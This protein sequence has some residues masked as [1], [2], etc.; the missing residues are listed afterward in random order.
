MRPSAR[1]LLGAAILLLA[2]CAEV[3]PPAASAAVEEHGLTAAQTATELFFSEYVE[4]TSNHKALEIYNGTGAAVDLGAGGYDVQMFFNGSPAA[5]LTIALTGTVAAGDVFVL[6]H[7]SADPAI[8]AVADQTNG[9][10][11]FN[12]DDAVVLRKAGVVIDS[13]GQAGFD[14]GS[15]WGTGLVST[16][17]NT[18]RRKASVTAGD[19]DVTDV[20]DPSV[21]WEGFA[22]NTFDGLGWHLEPGGD[23]EEPPTCEA[24]V[25]LT[26]VSAVQGPGAATPIGGSTVTIEGVVVGD[27]QDLPNEDGDVFGTDLGGFFVQEEDEDQDGD[28][29]T[30]EGVYVV[31][32]GVDV[33]V[34]DRVRV[35]GLVGEANGLTRLSNATAVVCEEDV[36]LPAAAELELPV[37]SLDDLEAY[38]G[39]LVTF[40]QELYVA[41]YFNFDRF[42]EI[43]LSA[44]VNGTRPYQPTSLLAS[45][46]PGVAALQD[47]I[48]R[49]RITLD[50]GR[51][52]Q[53]PDPARHPNGEVFDLTNLFRGGDTVRGV[54]GVLDFAFG[55]YRVQPTQ[56]AVHTPANP[57]PEEPD[58]VGGSVRAAA[59]NVLNYFDD[60]GASC[61]PAGDEDCRGADDAEEFARQRAKVVAAIAAMDAHV[62]GLI[63]IENDPDQ[64]ALKDLVAGLN[65]V[66]GAGRYAYVD[67]DGPVGTD[68]IKVA[69]VYQP[70]AVTPV[71]DPAVLD[72]EAFLDPNGS[73]E[74]RN[75]AALAQTFED[76]S[77]G[78]FTV[79]VN[80]L[81]SKG[82]ECGAGDDDPVE[83]SCALTRLQGALALMEWLAADPTGA[84]DPDFLLVGD[85]NSYAEEAPIAALVDG[86]FVDLL[87]EHVGELAYTYVFDG[88]LGYLDH[89]LASASLAPQVTG[90]TAWH[91]NADEVDLIDYDT[92][93]KLPNQAALYAPDPY[94]SSD[95]DP[96]IVGLDLNASPRCEQATPSL[97]TLWPANHRLV[98]VAIDVPDPEGDAVTVSV[99]S[100]FQDEPV[101]GADDGATSPDA[102]VGQGGALEL[103]AERSGAGN[104]RVYHVA[105]TARDATGSCR[106]VVTVAVPL[107]PAKGAV[108]DGPLYDA[109]A[110]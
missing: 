6:A 31:G 5:A 39:M 33:A 74:D 11:W 53:N 76:A 10:G 45:D 56:G 28:P 99:D 38:E 13:I 26:L 19:P 12:G 14:P 95:H 80:H 17:D 91:V 36:D 82:S 25:E 81:K 16:A 93:F 73:G 63:E 62:V 60:F 78:R 23:D 4:G 98:A 44:P 77:G 47:L 109:T 92:T 58:D 35:T 50:D 42:G 7:S 48:V 34:G 105:F 57:R 70:G 29:A 89:A 68:A 9:A 52:R 32:G 18:L 106:G 87:R 107:S 40:P 59:F 41:E 46:D 110:P 71:G 108:D 37:E 27:F 20:F 30:S 88:Q 21:E 22:T 101:D 85:L 96:V 103:R 65:D 51:S 3:T 100:V 79:V 43:V 2:A 8:L 64:G 84:G 86:G 55:L 1:S 97:A 75:R 69:L 66:A 54:T 102:V 94:R 67:T 61:G 90:A 104:G 15:E 24:D 72:D 83:G 49:S